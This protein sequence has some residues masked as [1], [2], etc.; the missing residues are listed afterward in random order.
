MMSGH[1]GINR[2]S[3]LRF[4]LAAISALLTIAVLVFAPGIVV[5]VGAVMTIVQL[6]RRSQ[7]W[8]WWAVLFVVA[9]AVFAADPSGIGT[10]VTLG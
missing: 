3:P 4:G 6:V 10:E 1:A 2:R 5:A 7:S 8:R 9:F